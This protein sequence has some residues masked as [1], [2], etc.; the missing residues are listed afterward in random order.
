M[1]STN[2][3]LFWIINGDAWVFGVA[4]HDPGIEFIKSKMADPIWC[5][6]RSREF[7][8]E[9]TLYWIRHLEFRDFNIGIVIN[10]PKN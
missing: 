6:F 1:K 10:D 3:S 2:S 8:S 9:Q 4:D 7:H 5:L